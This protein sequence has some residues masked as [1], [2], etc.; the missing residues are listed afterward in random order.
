MNVRRAIVALAISIVIHL[1]LSVTV[2]SLPPPTPKHRGG[3]E[4]WAD[5][6]GEAGGHNKIKLKVGPIRGEDGEILQMS[7][8]GKNGEPCFEYFGGIGIYQDGSGN[9]TDVIPNYPAARLGLRPGDHIF[10][11]QNIIGEIGSIITFSYI[12]GERI[13][14][15]TVKRERICTRHYK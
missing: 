4:A 12:R 8:R 3:E 5:K 14:T 13:E 11:I 10:E 9:V 7:P 2:A 6:D 15:V 1:C